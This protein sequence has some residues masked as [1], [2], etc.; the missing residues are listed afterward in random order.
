MRMVF[1]FLALLLGLIIAGVAAINNEVVTLNYYFGQLN[2]TL[3]MLILGSA[4]AGA[5][6]MGALGIYRSIHNYMGSQ[7][8]RGHKK[9]LQ[10]RVKVLEGEKKKMEDELMKHQK[11][12]NDIAV[13][14]HTDLEDEKRRLE[15][16]LRKQQKEHQETTEK[17][18]S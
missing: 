10:H 18:H 9:D 6:F 3:F 16:E 5:I 1:L 15:D 14:A 12:R 13:K 11:E 17:A 4:A 2:L 8:E 7:G